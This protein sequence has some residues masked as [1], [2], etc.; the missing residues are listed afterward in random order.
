MPTLTG[1]VLYR[2]GMAAGLGRRAALTVAL[3]AGALWAAWVAVSGLLGGADVYRQRPVAGTPW[4]A[5]ATGGAL[6]AAL[7]AT[8]GP[9]GARVLAA[10]RAAA[11]LVG[12]QKLRGVRGV[13]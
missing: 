12:P 6:G 2:G 3:S 11:P 8:R 5:L 10:P 9:G 7:L 13:F 1:V 4:I